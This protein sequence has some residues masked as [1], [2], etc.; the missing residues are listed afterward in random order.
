MLTELS[1]LTFLRTWETRL[2][3]GILQDPNAMTSRTATNGLKVSWRLMTTLNS[4]NDILLKRE[5]EPGSFGPGS[6]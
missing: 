3:T 1:T 6:N 2:T 4:H 5:E